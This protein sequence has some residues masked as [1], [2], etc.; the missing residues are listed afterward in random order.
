MLEFGAAPGETMTIVSVSDPQYT[1]R[2]MVTAVRHHEDY[3]EERELGPYAAG[4]TLVLPADPS[5]FRARLRAVWR[6]PH[7]A[8]DRESTTELRE[9]PGGVR[10]VRCA[11]DG[12]VRDDDDPL[13]WD[14]HLVVTVTRGGALHVAEP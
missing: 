12:V 14:W 1:R 9:L 13:L 3:D 5:G 6:A 7:E 4:T 2:F 11:D 10:L 8:H